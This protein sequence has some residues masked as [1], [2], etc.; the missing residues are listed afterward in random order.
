ML[1]YNKLA[2]LMVGAKM[3]PKPEKVKKADY[4]WPHIE[5]SYVG[6]CAG[7]NWPIHQPTYLGE[8]PMV[9]RDL[10]EG[11]VDENEETE[12]PQTEATTQTN[13]EVVEPVTSESEND[14]AP[15]GLGSIDMSD[16]KPMP[17]MLTEEEAAAL[18]EQLTAQEVDA[19]QVDAK[20]AAT[21]ASSSEDTTGETNDEATPDPVTTESDENSDSATDESDGDKEEEV[22]PT[23]EEKV[24]ETP[25]EQKTDKAKSGKKKSK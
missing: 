16:A 21:D 19:S 14:N 13:V 5:T 6:I 9:L 3:A 25:V 8:L 22:S 23:V 24:E 1:D 12:E 7:Q 10:Y 15:D 2:I 4:G 11:K 18:R 20:D 17:P